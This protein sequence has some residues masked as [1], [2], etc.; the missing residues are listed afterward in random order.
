MTPKY[1]TLN[2]L[3]GLFGIKLCFCAGLAG[4]DGA[5]SKNN[6]VKT[7][8]DRYIVSA[9]HIFGR[10]SIVDTKLLWDINRKPYASYRMVSLSMT[11]SDP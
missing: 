7:N 11:L 2:D 8:K 9:V 1:M 5:T 6:C 3:D 4:S 10:D